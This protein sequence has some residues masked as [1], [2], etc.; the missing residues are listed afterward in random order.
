MD[1][2]AIKERIYQDIGQASMCWENIGK[3]GVFDAKK[4]GEIAFELYH[5]IADVIDKEE[6]KMGKREYWETGR[7][8]Q[9]KTYLFGGSEE[10][11][12]FEFYVYVN[13]NGKIGKITCLFPSKDLFKSR[14]RL[15]DRLWFYR[16]IPSS[17]IWNVEVHHEWEDGA[18]VYLLSKEEHKLKHR[19]G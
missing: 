1:K 15:K 12:S 11:E 10:G 16:N 9:H 6:E 18:R 2:K 8:P 7:M 17:I 19:N 5:F 4:A 14:T 3:A 13:G